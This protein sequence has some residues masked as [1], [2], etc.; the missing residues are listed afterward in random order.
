MTADAGVTINLAC[1]YGEGHEKK[2]IPGVP[3]AI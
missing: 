2:V 1:T 3:G